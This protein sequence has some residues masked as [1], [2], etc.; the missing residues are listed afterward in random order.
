MLLQTTLPA[1]VAGEHE[2]AYDS[3][4]PGAAVSLPYN[5]HEWAGPPDEGSAA[6]V[7]VWM[8]NRMLAVRFSSD[9]STEQMLVGVRFY[10]AGDLQSF[11]VWLFDSQGAFIMTHPYVSDESGGYNPGDVPTPTPFTWTVTPASIGWVY[12]NTT[13]TFDPVFVVGDFYVAIEFTVSQKPALGV[14]TTGPR[15]NRGWFVDN[16]TDS[17]WVPYSSYAEQ[18]GL[19]DG[20]LMIRADISPIYD[21]THWENTTTSAAQS[22]KFPLAI[23]AP[24]GTL[25]AVLVVAVVGVWQVRKRRHIG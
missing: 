18:H 14:D 8:A 23:V 20:N 1:T 3:G 19:P 21:L 4:T 5:P 17:G 12:L 7:G 24:A 11:N 2:L 25:L 22:Q 10:I 16:Q 13:S 6:D 15:S 9:N